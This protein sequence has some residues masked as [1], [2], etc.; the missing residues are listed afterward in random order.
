MRM[1]ESIFARNSP[2]TPRIAIMWENSTSNKSF[3]RFRDSDYAP[4]ARRLTLRF[5]RN[6]QHDLATRVTGRRL[7]LRPRGVGQWQ[8]LRDNDLDLFVVDQ[9][10]DLSELV[11]IR[12]HAERCAADPVF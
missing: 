12:L 4:A 10:T 6:F 8:H 2:R 11:G 3:I 7:F 9:L 5:V 1:S